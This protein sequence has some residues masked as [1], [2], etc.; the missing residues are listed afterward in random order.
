MI[1]IYYDIVYLIEHA[2]YFLI[3]PDFKI[4]LNPVQILHY[5]L[6]NCVAVLKHI[7]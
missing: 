4:T 3:E 1:H 6:A 5:R 7:S 2:V